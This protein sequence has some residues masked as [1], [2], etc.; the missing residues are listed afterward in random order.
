MHTPQTHTPSQIT[1]SGE[2]ASTE[3]ILKFSKL[4][5]D[6]LTLDNLSQP[7]LKALCKSVLQSAA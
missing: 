6:E 3:E 2:Q 4:F 7:Q 1:G 5:E